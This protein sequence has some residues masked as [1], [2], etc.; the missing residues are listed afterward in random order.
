M[1]NT[2]IREALGWEPSIGLRTGMEE[3]YR[4]IYDQVKARAEGRP[5]VAA[6][7]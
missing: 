5:F 4:W 3:T 7:E 1:L 6:Y 2:L